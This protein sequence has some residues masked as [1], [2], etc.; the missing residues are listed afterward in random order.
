MD[1]GKLHPMKNLIFFGNLTVHYKSKSVLHT[2]ADECKSPASK[3]Y[4]GPGCSNLG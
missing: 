4:P 2:V 3:C 1:I